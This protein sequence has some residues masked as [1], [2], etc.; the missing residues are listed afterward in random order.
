MAPGVGAGDRMSALAA[1]VLGQRWRA[2]LLGPL[3]ILLCCTYFTPRRRIFVP[4]AAAL[5]LSVCCLPRM[6][7]TNARPVS[8]VPMH[9]C[10][11]WSVRMPSTVARLLHG[12][13]A[14]HGSNGTTRPVS[15]CMEVNE[16]A[17]SLLSYDQLYPPPPDAALCR[18]ALPL[19]LLLPVKSGSSELF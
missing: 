10:K 5:R 17:S 6:R 7:L 19:L 2:P 18:Q 3:P 8:T 9:L 4:W 1:H 14:C 11:C 12:A 13:C 15:L 16:Q